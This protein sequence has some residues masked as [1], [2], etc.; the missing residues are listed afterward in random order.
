M[1]YLILLTLVLSSLNVKAQN[2]FKKTSCDINMSIKDILKE[3]FQKDCKNLKDKIIVSFKVKVP[4][5][6]TV[7]VKGNL[8]NDKATDYISNEKVGDKI[9]IFNIKVKNNIPVHPITIT[10]KE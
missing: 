7:F 6:K 10:I 1:K 5:Q 2:E 3:G 9:T 4:K 8:L